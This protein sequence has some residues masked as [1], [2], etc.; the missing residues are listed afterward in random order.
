ML[1]GDALVRADAVEQRWADCLSGIEMVPAECA[2]DVEQHTPGGDGRE[3]LDA[4][5]PGTAA[6]D[7][8]SRVAVVHL[9]ITEDVR[10]RVPLSSALQEQEQTVVR[11]AP[12]QAVVLAAG[13][14]VG[15]GGD[16]LVHRVDPAEGAGLR[17]VGVERQLQR[18]HR[19]APDQGG[20][21]PGFIRSDMIE[22]AAL[23]AGSPPSPVAKPT[24]VV[25]QN[26]HR[27][28]SC[29]L[30]GHAS[31]PMLLRAA[32]QSSTECETDWQARC[33]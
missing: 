23:V 10:Q 27:E 8:G 32:R 2:G 20:R 30:R 15:A 12:A 1:H 6:G 3:V 25:L 18:E 11:V 31:L 19:A 7:L 22:G 16:H 26:I 21:P 14:M 5:P 17:P 33:T 4:V 13:G 29:G 9:L 28:R 24:V